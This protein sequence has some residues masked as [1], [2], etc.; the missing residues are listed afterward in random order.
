MYLKSKYLK[1]T[2]NTNFNKQVSAAFKMLEERSQSVYEEGS[3]LRFEKLLAIDLELCSLGGLRFGCYFEIDKTQLG[4]ADQ[5]ISVRNTDQ[6]CLLYS[7][8]AA[9]NGHDHED[10]E[11]P[12]VYDEIVNTYN[13]SEMQFPTNITDVKKFVKNNKKSLDLSVNIFSFFH[14]EII[15]LEIGI[16]KGKNVVNLLAVWYNKD[17]ET[18]EV[19]HQGYGHYMVIKDFDDFITPLRNKKNPQKRKRYHCLRCYRTFTNKDTRDDHNKKLC[20]MKGNIAVEVMPEEEQTVHFKNLDNQYLRPLIGF[21]DLE[22]VIR[23]VADSRI[24]DDCVE[25]GMTCKCDIG[26]SYTI[27]D[28]VHAPII[29]SI[30]IV[31]SANKLIWEETKL[32]ED[33]HVALMKKLIE[34]Q[35]EFIAQMSAYTPL[36]PNELIQ[37]SSACSHCGL[38]WTMECTGLTENCGTCTGYENDDENLDEC[39]LC[40]CEAEMHKL[41]DVVRDH[42]HYSGQ[43]LGLCHK[44]CN[45][46]RENDR[47]QKLVIPL[48]AHNATNY[49][50][51]FML[52]AAVA[53]KIEGLLEE[54]PTLLPINQE[55]FRWMKVG[56]YQFLDSFKFMSHSL[57]NLIKDLTTRSSGDKMKILNQSSLT[58]YKCATIIGLDEEKR[59]ACLRKGELPYEKKARLVLSVF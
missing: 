8:A 29:Y 55:T 40:G 16:G 49:D 42:D 53:C 14:E 39:E 34:K 43:F 47:T 9:L 4:K 10:E 12:D 5:L 52:K 38:G 24:T 50:S 45:L 6:R 15:P 11:D 27:K 30:C 17:K 23:P 2:L 22:S 31:D 1:C 28:S 36:N 18:I 25:C 37:P 41:K 35:E 20:V 58:Q 51:H 46:N 57:E 48:Y 44:L 19:S 7:V 56:L 26:K 21:Y 3:G 13:I 59:D 54:A 32:V 33:A